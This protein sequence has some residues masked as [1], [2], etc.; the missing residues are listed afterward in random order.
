MPAW[1][2]APLVI[3][4]DH[5]RFDMLTVGRIEQR[6]RD[7]LTTAWFG[8][9]RFGATAIPRSRR[10]LCSAPGRGAAK[11]R[12][13]TAAQPVSRDPRRLVS[14]RLSLALLTRV[15]VLDHAWRQHDQAREC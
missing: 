13:A 9:H 3:G 7:G 11:S 2:E 4:R 1:V 8:A 15:A 14:C 12:S 6:E 10:L 5:H